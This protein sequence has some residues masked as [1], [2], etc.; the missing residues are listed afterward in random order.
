MFRRACAP[1]ASH[2]LTSWPPPSQNTGPRVACAQ[3][4]LATPMPQ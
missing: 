4:D 1:T 2:P 3:H